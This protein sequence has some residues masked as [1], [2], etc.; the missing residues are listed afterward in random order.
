MSSHRPCH[1]KVAAEDRGAAAAVPAR[2][3]QLGPA[4]GS[5]RRSQ[6]SIAMQRLDDDLFC[7]R[8]RQLRLVQSHARSGGAVQSCCASFRW[9]GC[10]T[11]LLYPC[12][13][14]L[15]WAG[16]RKRRCPIVVRTDRP[17]KIPTQLT[18]NGPDGQQRLA[19]KGQ[20]VDDWPRLDASMAPTGAQQALGRVAE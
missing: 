20:I 12:W 2:P 18:A 3:V 15:L 5:T 13:D 8:D 1:P 4:P 6:V 19:P 9:M 7:V 16:G 14:E 11:S 10:C 17:T